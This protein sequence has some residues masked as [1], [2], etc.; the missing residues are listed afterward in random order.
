MIFWTQKEAIALCTEIEQF[1]P[2]YGVHVALTGGLLY[3][4][5]PRKDCDILF[6]RIEPSLRAGPLDLK[7]LLARLETIGFAQ[8]VPH[9]QHVKGF[10]KHRI[11]DLMF[12][13]FETVN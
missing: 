2:Q 5:G 12:P 11:I 6:Y 13:Q 8:L 4:T 9:A 7:G 10:Y 3:K 1:C